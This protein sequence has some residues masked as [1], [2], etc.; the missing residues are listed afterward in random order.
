MLQQP[1]VAPAIP[2]A[3]AWHWTG[4]GLAMLAT[5]AVFMGMAAYVWRRRGGSAG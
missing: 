3:A 2:V 4:V 1:R 5:T